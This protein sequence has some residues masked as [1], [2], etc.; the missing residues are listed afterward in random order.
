MW[1]PFSWIYVSINAKNLTKRKYF[2]GL[3]SNNAM[4]I[5]FEMLEKVKF[6]KTINKNHFSLSQYYCIKY[7]IA[8]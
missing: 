2:I 5:N 1:N 4:L 6:F 3:F 8:A 7:K